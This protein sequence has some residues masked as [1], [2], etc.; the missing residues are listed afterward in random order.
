MSLSES[1]TATFSG[2]LVVVTIALV[3]VSIVQARFAFLL[4]RATQ[5]LRSVQES[6]QDLEKDRYSPTPSVLTS[7]ITRDKKLPGFRVALAINNPGEADL[8]IQSAAVYLG[9][10]PVTE[11]V[12][13]K[14]SEDYTDLE[15]QR[16]RP[17]DLKEFE[18]EVGTQETEWFNGASIVIF[19]VSGGREQASSED[20][21]RL[22]IRRKA[23]NT[24]FLVPVG[25][26]RHVVR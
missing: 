23:E 17:H 3:C 2:L 7:V 26:G 6:F 16:I 4:W 14:G 20:W 11:A 18:V 21:M 19:Y 22:S 25:K 10:K 8:F 15:K 5:R 9:E 24:G 12:C 1:L 13:I